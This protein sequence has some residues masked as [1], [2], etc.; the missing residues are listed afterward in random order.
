MSYVQNMMELMLYWCR[1]RDTAADTE[2]VEM[3]II[4]RQMIK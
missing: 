4:L 2:T 3:Y 1:R